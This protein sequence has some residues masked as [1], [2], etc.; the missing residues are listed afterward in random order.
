MLIFFVYLTFPYVGLQPNPAHNSLFSLIQ[1]LKRDFRTKCLKREDDKRKRH[2]KRED[3]TSLTKRKNAH[4]LTP[5]LRWVSKCHPF[6]A[7]L[8]R[9][10]K[11]F[12]T[13]SD[14]C[15]FRENYV[16]LSTHLMESLH[17]NQQAWLSLGRKYGD[18]RDLGWEAESNAGPP[19]QS[20]ARPLRLPDGPHCMRGLPKMRAGL[21]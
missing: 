18:R 12:V 13:H 17:E 21:Q 7:A 3:Y 10:S 9:L 20:P 6:W 14:L 19:T 2:R 15:S 1:L 16:P 8:L 5:Y 4:E 11:V